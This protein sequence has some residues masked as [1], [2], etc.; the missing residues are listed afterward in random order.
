MFQKACIVPRYARRRTHL[1][2]SSS[3]YAGILW[4]ICCLALFLYSW[5][6]YIQW[7]C[8]IC[9]ILGSP[10]IILLFLCYSRIWEFLEAF[11]VQLDKIALPLGSCYF[12]GT[13]HRRQNSSLIIP[14][15]S[16][17]LIHLLN[18]FI[19][20][21]LWEKLLCLIISPKCFFHN[22]NLF[23]SVDCT[24]FWMTKPR[25]TEPDF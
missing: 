1:I 5:S 9:S 12:L 4:V 3:F 19:S 11:K 16:I 13:L 6:I 18:L 10:G 7:F 17:L 14:L 8:F 20:L 22:W 15:T 25:R 24:G 2:F 23:H 21:Q